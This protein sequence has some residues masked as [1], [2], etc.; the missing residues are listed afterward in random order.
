MFASS[1]FKA[2][3]P[4]LMR[5]FCFLFFCGVA[6]PSRSLLLFVMHCLFITAISR[7]MAYSLWLICTTVL[8]CTRSQSTVGDQHKART[9]VCLYKC[10]LFLVP[11]DNGR[12]KHHQLRHRP[13]CL[14]WSRSVEVA[15]HRAAVVAHLVPVGFDQLWW[16]HRFCFCRACGQRRPR[17]TPTAQW[18]SAS[19]H[20]LKLF[21]LQ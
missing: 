6:L 17:R 16:T 9:P 3:V 10:D 4:W 13:Q 18:D 2:P 5:C 7:S 19:F 12:A 15:Q 1:A 11:K 14:R 21:G 8:I 20:L